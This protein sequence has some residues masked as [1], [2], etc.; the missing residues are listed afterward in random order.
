MHLYPQE[1]TVDT[2]AVLVTVAVAV[3]VVKIVEVSVAV[4]AGNFEEQ[5]LCA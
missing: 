1:L 4:L 2:T 5:K 3:L